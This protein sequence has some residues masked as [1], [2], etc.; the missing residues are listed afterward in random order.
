M[1]V[2]D[3]SIW[4]DHFRKSDLQLECLLNDGKALTHPLVIGE[5]ACGNFKN[6]QLIFSLLNA[7][8]SISEISGEEYFI[9]LERHRLFGTG[10]GF[11]DIN[12]LAAAV[13]ADCSIYTR[14]KAL[15]GVAETF[16]RSFR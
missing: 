8:P 7:L 11:V 10:P 12:L 3:T 5:L 9:F 4:I 14:D 15:H 2:I 6:R 13:L 1:V 16:D